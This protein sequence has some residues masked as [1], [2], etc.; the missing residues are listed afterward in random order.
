MLSI[1]IKLILYAF[2]YFTISYPSLILRMND[3]GEYPICK[4]ISEDKTYFTEDIRDIRDIR[5]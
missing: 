3:N 1:I 2:Y 4:W 5:D